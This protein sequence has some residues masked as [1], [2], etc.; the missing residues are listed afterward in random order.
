MAN[1]PSIQKVIQH[2]QKDKIELQRKLDE[3]KK[4]KLHT[5]KLILFPRYQ[6]KVVAISTA[7]TYNAEILKRIGGK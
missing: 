3:M 4:S 2:L 5:L 1:S 7:L 6:S